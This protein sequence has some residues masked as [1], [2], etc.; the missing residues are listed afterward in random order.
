MED[1]NSGNTS[2]DLG[3]GSELGGAAVEPQGQAN[4]S[5]NANLGATSNGGQTSEQMVDIKWNGKVE[6]IPYS[7]ALELAQ[8][9]FDYTQKMQQLARER[10]DFG[11][12]RQRYD[13]AFSEVRSFLQDKAKVREYLQKLEGNAQGAAMQAQHSGD[14]DDIVTAQQFQ[15]RLAEAQ[16]EFQGFAQDQISQLRTQM[17]TEQLAG[18]FTQDLNNHINGL[19]RA[20]P[21]LGAIPRIAQILKE[22]VKAMGPQSIAEAK[23][24]MVEVAKQHQAS[25]QKHFLEQ[26]KQSGGGAGT[27]P[28]K[29]GI[30]PAGGAPPVPVQNTDK[31]SG[32]IK[33]PAFK[34]SIVAEL[35]ALAQK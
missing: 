29:N 14:P 17:A 19:K 26:R 23:E 2:A 34:Q 11:S 32:G 22:D 21:E 28:L 15:Q 7:R 13:Q 10:E 3:S 9:G 6:K 24:M 33:N 12:T 4:S 16:R 25:I 31:Y 18:Q 8:K 27:N 35:T 5:A 1:F 20:M 30:E